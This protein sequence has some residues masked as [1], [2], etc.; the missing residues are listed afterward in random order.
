M[1]HYFFYVLVAGLRIDNQSVIVNYICDNT[2]F[3]CASI[4]LVPENK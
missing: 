1:N 2:T 4:V 3:L